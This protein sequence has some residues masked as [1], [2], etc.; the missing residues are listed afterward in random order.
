MLKAR[1]DG[2]ECPLTQKRRSIEQR[3]LSV[4]LIALRRVARRHAKGVEQ[5]PFALRINKLG[6]TS[7]E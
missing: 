1:H 3:F 7:G 2:I 5:R 4:L 6:I